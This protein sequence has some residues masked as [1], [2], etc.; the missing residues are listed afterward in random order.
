MSDRMRK[1]MSDRMPGEMADRLSG[2][3]SDIMSEYV[4]EKMTE[5][6]KRYNICQ[7][8]LLQWRSH[9]VQ[10]LMFFLV[11]LQFS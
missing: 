10:L 6:K 9:V 11:I 4:S 8:F 7:D 2:K 5:K 1:Y 3:M